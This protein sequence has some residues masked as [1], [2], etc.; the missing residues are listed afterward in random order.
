MGFYDHMVP[1]KH[2]APVSHE[3]PVGARYIATLT[4]PY[5][6]SQDNTAE[7]AQHCR[8]VM[9]DFDRVQTIVSAQTNERTRVSDLVH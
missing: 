8:Q 2:W 3:A 6:L 5:W 4:I 9:L 7:L 1:Y